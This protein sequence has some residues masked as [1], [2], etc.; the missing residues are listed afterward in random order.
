M[1]TLR[2]RMADFGFESN[3]DYGYH[4]RCVLSQPTRQVPALNVEGDSGRR[5]T[6][7]A[8]AL[9]SALDYSQRVYHDFTQQHEPPPKVIPLPSKDEDG[10]EEPPIPAFERVMSDA[11]AYS[12]GE[13]TILILDQLQTADFREHIRLYEFLTNAEWHFRDATFSANPYNLLVLLISEEPLYHSLQKASFS[14]WV[15]KASVGE[16]DYEPADFG[17]GPEANELMEHLGALFR[18]LGVQPTPSEFRKLL[19]DIQQNVRTPDQLTHSIYGWTEGIDR[20]LLLADR[21]QRRIHELMP[22]LEEYV[23]V[24]HVELRSL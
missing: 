23:G 14:A 11:C 7:F 21:V 20:T 15:P 24:E 12:E 1:S 5:K 4:L 3:I 8:S 19:N 22:V 17:L 18:E 16:S 10:R 13:K 2:E 6:A 9:A